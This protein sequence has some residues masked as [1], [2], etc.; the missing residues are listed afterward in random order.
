L[1]LP[2]AEPI[3]EFLDRLAAF[4]DWREAALLP[5]EWA[6]RLAALNSLLDP[7]RPDD[8]PGHDP[9]REATAGSGPLFNPAQINVWRA[10][11]LAAAAWLAAL[12]ETAS[13]LPNEPV[14]LSS[15]MELAQPSLRDATLP[16][17]SSGATPSR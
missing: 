16:I 7:P 9:H 8:G 5:V 11:A 1:T 2:G 4:G 3:V 10:R 6:V 12:N 14:S 15:F 13:L 17:P